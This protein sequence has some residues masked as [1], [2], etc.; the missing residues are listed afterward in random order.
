M[1]RFGLLTY[2]TRATISAELSRGVII[3]RICSTH[4]WRRRPAG[5][6]FVVLAGAMI[7]KYEEFALRRP[8]VPAG[9]GPGL[10]SGLAIWTCSRSRGTAEQAQFG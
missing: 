4:C 3:T 2:K 5:L 9:K 7:L 10:S 1:F 6:D 8:F